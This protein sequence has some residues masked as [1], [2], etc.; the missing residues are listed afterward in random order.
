MEKVE[1]FSM[2]NQA[3]SP[4]TPITD[5]RIDP[6]WFAFRLSRTQ[7]LHQTVM[8]ISQRNHDPNNLNRLPPDVIRQINSYLGVGGR[9]RLSHTHKINKT[10]KGTTNK[11]HL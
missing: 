2:V 9:R 5:I 3:T 6:F 10:K 1:L 4:P 8:N 11:K 7:C